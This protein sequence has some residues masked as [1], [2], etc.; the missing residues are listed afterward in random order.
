MCPTQNP[1]TSAGS[2]PLVGSAAGACPVP[3]CDRLSAY[4]LFHEII[5]W[6][7]RMFAPTDTSGP[8]ILAKV[9]ERYPVERIT[10]RA[11]A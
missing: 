11:A 5:S 1:A 3:A 4:G 6:K 9:M 2:L 10:E 8:A 7:L